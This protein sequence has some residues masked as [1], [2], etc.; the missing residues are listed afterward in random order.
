MLCLDCG[1]EMRLVQ[2]TEDTTM[3]V[4]G[5]EHHTWQC[6]GCST[7]ERRMIFTREK[8]P[9]PSVTIE[10][11]HVMRAK[12]VQTVPIEPTS[13]QSAQTA[14][15]ETTVQVKASQTKAVEKTQMPVQPAIQTLPLRTNAW[16]KA[17]EKVHERE[18]A[19]RKAADAA[20]RSAEFKA[21]WDNLLSVPSPS[22]SSERLSHQKA[23]DLVRSSAEPIASPAPTA[24]DEP[25][26]PEQRLRPPRP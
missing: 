19:Q 3:F 2:V 14:P 20:K 15:V 12:P 7:T 6:T 24:P 11:T 23:D 8:T 26:R 16:V 21:F 18:T 9:T 4:S 13:V 17:V 25:C 5:Y 1:A 10:Q 22:T